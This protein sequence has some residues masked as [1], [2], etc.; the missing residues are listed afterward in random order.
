VQALKKR[1]P[2]S[3]VQNR[4]IPPDADAEFV[5][6]MVGVTEV[7]TRPYDPR[8]P[9]ACFDEACKQLLVVRRSA[10]AP[11]AP[12]GGAAPARL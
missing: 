10:P 11:A 5:W 6:R 2:A 9:A 3:I 12:A 8:F 1:H 4:C 7:D